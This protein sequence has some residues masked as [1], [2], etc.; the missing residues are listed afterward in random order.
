MCLHMQKLHSRCLLKIQ[1]TYDLGKDQR[2]SPRHGK[3]GVY[4]WEHFTVKSERDNFALGIGKQIQG[5][6]E[7][8]RNDPLDRHNGK[9]FATEDKW[10]KWYQNGCA[11]DYKAGWWYSNCFD[12]C[13]N[14]LRD[15]ALWKKT[16]L[17]YDGE[18]E[19]PTESIM[20][21]KRVD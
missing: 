10:F 18:Y 1:V 14:C 13:L 11:Q 15:R 6:D 3:T 4:E 20:W 9:P 16:G 17:L 19:T 7:G 8:H 2:P 5:Q 12:I 21:M